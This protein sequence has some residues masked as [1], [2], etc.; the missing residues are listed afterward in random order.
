MCYNNNSISSLSWDDKPIL[1]KY[2]GIAHIEHFSSSKQFPLV[3]SELSLRS[4]LKTPFYACM[5]R[6]F[7]TYK[8]LC[9][10]WSMRSPIIA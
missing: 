1:L 5:N 3:K 2:H 6:V 4:S 9:L 7:A 10:N 8:I